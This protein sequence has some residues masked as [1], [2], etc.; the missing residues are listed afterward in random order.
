MENTTPAGHLEIKI[1]Q[2]AQLKAKPDYS[3]LGFGKHFTDHMF[4]AKYNINKGWYSA[5]I[6]P[7]EDLSI[8]PA[9]SVLHYGQALFEGMK[10]FRQTDNSISLFRSKFNWERMVEGA[11]RLCLEAPPLALFQEGIQKLVQIDHEW[12]PTPEQGSLYIRPTLIGTEGFL[13]IRP[14]HDYIFFVILS[15][16]STYYSEGLSPVK[17]WVEDQYL[18]AAPGGLGHTKAGAN[19]ASSL[20][21]GLNAKQKGYSQVLWLDVE[22]KYVE[23][24]GTMN[25][26]FVLGDEIVTPQLSGTILGG[27]VRDSVIRLLGSKG[28]HVQQR[29]ISVEELVT[30]SKAGSFKEAFGTGTAAVIS[31]VGK[32]SSNSWDININNGQS[33]PI[34]TL[35][36]KELTD[37]QYGRKPDPFTWMEPIL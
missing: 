28:Y 14:S 7:F 18:R 11:E 22:K 19:Y 32:L 3:E 20:K 10:A 33:G 15:P 35:L 26:F 27:G 34:S 2:R 1:N 23:E 5:Q 8:H 31:P 6:C 30:A 36:Y 21:A 25:V 12:V 29:K 24:V 13:G 17:I 4:V 16:V 37:I 9:A